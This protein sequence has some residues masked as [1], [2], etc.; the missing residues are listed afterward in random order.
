MQ[1]QASSVR[2]Q[3]FMER[4]VAAFEARRSFGKMLQDV[5]AKGD[6]FVV[7]RHGEPVA[8][9]VPITVYEQWKRERSAFFDKL[10]EIQD[11]I[12]LTPAEADQLAHEVVQA[13][14]KS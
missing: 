8:A 4:I 1:T 9:V 7:E 13:V 14:R 2:T 6:K 11:R 3:G 12:D 10:R 5:L